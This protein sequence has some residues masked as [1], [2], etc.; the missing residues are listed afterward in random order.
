MAQNKTEHKD[1]DTVYFTEGINVR[2]VCT[3]CA[4]HYDDKPDSCLVCNKNDF[5]AKAQRTDPICFC[6]TCSKYFPYSKEQV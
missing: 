4:A 3:R 1:H 2:F 5:I 6:F